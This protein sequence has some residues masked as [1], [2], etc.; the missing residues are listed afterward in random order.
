LGN[1]AVVEA[2]VGIQGP[3]WRNITGVASETSNAVLFFADKTLNNTSAYKA[4]SAGYCYNLLATVHFYD[5]LKPDLI[6]PATYTHSRADRMISRSFSDFYDPRSAAG[7]NIYTI[8]LDAGFSAGGLIKHD[9][10]RSRKSIRNINGVCRPD[11]LVR[12]GR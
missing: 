7:R 3:Q 4:G 8:E 1:V 11:C 6:N 10:Q 5:I 9:L 2:D 12:L